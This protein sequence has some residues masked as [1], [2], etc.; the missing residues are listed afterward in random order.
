MKKINWWIVGGV[1]AA[2][3]VGAYLA[4]QHFTKPGGTSNYSAPGK[5][6][7]MLK[8]IIQREKLMAN[9][10]TRLKVG[11][12]QRMNPNSQMGLRK[13]IAVQRTILIN[14]REQYNKAC[15]VSTNAPLA[16]ECDCNKNGS[17]GTLQVV[18]HDSGGNNVYGCVPGGCP[19]A[20]GV[21]Y[22][23]GTH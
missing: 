19:G 10:Q 14:M 15:G 11:I 13:A 16:S 1:A 3:G 21:P 12:A 2:S 17:G 8:Q 18:G 5:C 23:A 7:V 9:L 6:D 22:N 20:N 4:F